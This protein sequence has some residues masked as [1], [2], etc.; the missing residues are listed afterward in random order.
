MWKGSIEVQTNHSL[1]RPG[2][3][4]AFNLHQCIQSNAVE[5]GEG[6]GEGERGKEGEG[7]ERRRGEGRKERGGKEGEGRERGWERVGR[8]EKE[9][10]GGWKGE[11]MVGVAKDMQQSQYKSVV[12]KIIATIKELN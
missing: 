5:K 7:R 4:Q 8:R 12:L 11:R 1:H 3:M 9:R 6:E 2:E 10:H